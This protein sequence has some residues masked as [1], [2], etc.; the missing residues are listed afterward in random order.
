MKPLAFDGN[1][2]LRRLTNRTSFQAAHTD[3]QMSDL[4]K[5][6]D[7]SD[8]IKVISTRY[9]NI[10]RKMHARSQQKQNGFP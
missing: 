6:Y 9:W 10:G 5:V 1:Q 4:R 3:R 2:T 7:N 8:L